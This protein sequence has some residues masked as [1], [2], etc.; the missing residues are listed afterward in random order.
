MQEITNFLN[1]WYWCYPDLAHG[2]YLCL[3]LGVLAFIGI[4]IHD[5]W[6][7]QLGKSSDGLFMEIVVTFIMCVVGAIFAWAWCPALIVF[8]T[9]CLI[10]KGLSKWG[11]NYRDLEKSKEERQ[12]EA[13]KEL[14]E[15]D[16]VFMAKYK[17]LME[18]TPN[19]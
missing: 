5:S 19:I 3:I 7:D 12:R 14:I 18:T 16:P 11:N 10:N 13:L 2:A 4:F 9:F 15:S 1:W 17:E 6:T 8:G